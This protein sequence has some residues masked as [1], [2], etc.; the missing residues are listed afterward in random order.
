MPLWRESQPLVLAS[1]SEIRRTVLTAAGIPVEIV[2]A[3]IDERAVEAAAQPHNPRAAAALLAIAKAEAVMARMPGRLVLGADQVLA[4]GSQRFTKPD[5]RGAARA[6]LL[7]LRGKTHELHSAIALMRDGKALFE[8]VGE[9][10]LLMRP[11]SDA[12][13]DAYLDAAGDSVTHSVGGYQLENHG[14][15]LF[16]RIDGDHFTILGLPLL[17]LLGALREAGLVAG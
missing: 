9:A 7:A 2:P 15:H 5:G 10:R 11:F 16:E 14:V 12:F 6:Q 1:K 8:F 4:L 17:P 3:G 13:L